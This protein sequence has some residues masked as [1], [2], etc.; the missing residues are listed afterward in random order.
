MYFADYY[1]RGKVLSEQVARRHI[2]RGPDE[3][4][5]HFAGGAS[6]G[7]EESAWVS[8]NLT[9]LR[10]SQSPETQPG[11]RFSL[12]DLKSIY[13]GARVIQGSI[14]ASQLA[15][16]AVIEAGETLR[17]A[18]LPG[19]LD[20]FAR[21]GT[22]QTEL[23]LSGAHRGR[24]RTENDYPAAV[25]KYIAA[26]AGILNGPYEKA[27][28]RLETHRPALWAL[29]LDAD[30]LQRLCWGHLRWRINEVVPAE[31]L[32]SYRSKPL[33]EGTD[34]LLALIKE[35]TGVALPPR[36]VQRDS[37]DYIDPR[38]DWL[39]ALG[40]ARQDPRLALLCGIRFSVENA[41]IS[42]LYG[43]GSLLM[44]MTHGAPTDEVIRQ[45][46]RFGVQD[47]AWGTHLV[48]HNARFQSRV[49]ARPNYFRSFDEF[50]RN[51][52][53]QVGASSIQPDGRIDYFDTHSPRTR[54]WCPAQ[55]RYDGKGSDA[56]TGLAKE[57]QEAVASWTDYARQK[58]GVVPEY[59][60][61]TAGELLASVVLFAIL[62]EG[63]PL[64]P[65]SALMHELAASLKDG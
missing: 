59:S 49:G 23:F 13:L 37:Q 6:P 30:E 44:R 58:F 56:L 61:A 36:I 52:R 12:K 2:R 32:A 24:A 18:A 33:Q 31:Q 55:N 25:K 53:K 43:L 8:Q 62:H 63:S 29:A 65:E 7:S 4:T 14:M 50:R 64:Y 27:Y 16:P 20:S 15:L 22:A 26:I 19:D 35:R 60:E 57:G 46:V 9:E 10:T 47:I 54:G 51:V 42:T 5:A 48:T 34:E 45:Q 39:T 21:T 3:L 17:T 38:E 40:N 11:N 1:P 41:E 28:V